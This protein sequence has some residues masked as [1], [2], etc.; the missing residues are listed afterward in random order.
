MKPFNIEEVEQGKPVITRDG[1]KAEILKTDLKGPYPVLSIITQNDG[2]ET[3]HG[4]Y[5]DG[6]CVKCRPTNDDLFIDEED[7]SLPNEAF[8]NIYY[9]SIPFP[10]SVPV[11]FA[12][13]EV[14]LSEK[15]AKDN[16]IRN[17]V[18]V[19]TAKVQLSPHK[20]TI[21]SSQD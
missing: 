19:T 4:M 3:I 15:E 2:S 12:D 14:Y 18:L 13:D 21:V 1:R 11:M 6:R 10:G 17:L 8:I 20:D 7:P 5:A 9:R 16:I